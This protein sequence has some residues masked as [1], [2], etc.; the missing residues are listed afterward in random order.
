MYVHTSTC[1][2][3]REERAIY[4]MELDNAQ[5]KGNAS[6]SY[7]SI[8]SHTARV[9]DTGYKIGMSESIYMKM[10]CVGFNMLQNRSP[11][12]TTVT[13]DDISSLLNV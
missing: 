1:S 9:S 5:H 2:H 8:T 13:A 11:H 12:K 4:I 10:V 7:V 6:P 3:P